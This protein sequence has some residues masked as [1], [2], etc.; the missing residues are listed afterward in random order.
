[1]L[2]VTKLVYNLWQH[3]DGHCCVFTLYNERVALLMSICQSLEFIFTLQYFS[4]K[5]KPGKWR[6]EKICILLE[7]WIKQSLALGFCGKHWAKSTSFELLFHFRVRQR[8]TIKGTAMPGE[9]KALRRLRLVH[10][11]ATSLL[12][13]LLPPH[14]PQEPRRPMRTLTP[15]KQVMITVYRLCIAK[16]TQPIGGSKGLSLIPKFTGKQFWF[17]EGV[18]SVVFFP[19]SL[20]PHHHI[21]T[22]YSSGQGETHELMGL[23]PCLYLIMSNTSSQLAVLFRANK[24]SCES[25]RTLFA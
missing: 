25:F 24:V 2:S 20:H 3:H 16:W 7:N 15:S 22:C 23:F 1:M 21:I 12:P 8:P 14:H 13:G 10:R 18:R 4:P 11:K 9:W 6:R 19:S 17:L 5:Y